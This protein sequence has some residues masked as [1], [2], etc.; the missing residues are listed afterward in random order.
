MNT[1]KM[2]VWFRPAIW[3][4]SD[5]LVTPK[6]MKNVEAPVKSQTSWTRVL[7]TPST[8]TVGSAGFFVKLNDS[9]IIQKNQVTHPSPVSHSFQN[10][11]FKSK[12]AQLPWNTISQSSHLPDCDNSPKT[13]NPAR[14]HRQK[15]TCRAPIFFQDTWMWDRS[16]FLRQVEGNVGHKECSGSLSLMNNIVETLCSILVPVPHQSPV[17]VTNK[18]LMAWLRPI[19][20]CCL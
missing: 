19:T 4:V 18:F 12:R 14:I 2:E 16:I 1:V 15:E 9:E 13:T 17:L 7:L 3:V 20:H 6:V 11:I 8:T 10:L 5:S